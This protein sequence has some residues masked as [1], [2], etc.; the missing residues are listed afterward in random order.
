[1]YALNIKA[2]IVDTGI[3]LG[4]HILGRPLRRCAIEENAEVPSP[5]RGPVSTVEEPA[6]SGLLLR[7]QARISR[8]LYLSG[9][10]LL[11]LRVASR[12][13]QPT[14]RR[15][16]GL[17]GLFLLEKCFLG[18]A[19]TSCPCPRPSVSFFESLKRRDRFLFRLSPFASSSHLVNSILSRRPCIHRKLDYFKVLRWHGSILSS[20]LCLFSLTR[21]LLCSRSF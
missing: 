18:R 15:R 9:T 6:I 7:F 19:L 2:P 20:P 16:G 14:P 5:R 3:E 11:E 17:P 13:P 10:A 4:K 8:I 21:S 12:F 1:M